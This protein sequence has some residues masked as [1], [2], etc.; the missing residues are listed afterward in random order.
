M[1]DANSNIVKDYVLLIREGEKKIDD[2][3]SY[4]SLR[5]VVK[6]VLENSI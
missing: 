4:K 1:F 2:V 3:P 5:D 6:S